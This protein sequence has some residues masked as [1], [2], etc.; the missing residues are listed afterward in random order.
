MESEQYESKEKFEALAAD[1]LQRYELLRRETARLQET[2]DFLEA[3]CIAVGNLLLAKGVGTLADLRR[4]T[5]AAIAE[6]TAARHRERPTTGV[7]R[8]ETAP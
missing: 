3:E 1:M 5:A 8:P 4:Y 2:V 6:R 7:T